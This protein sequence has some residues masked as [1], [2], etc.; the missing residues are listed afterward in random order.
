MS[1]TSCVLILA[2]LVCANGIGWSEEKDGDPDSVWELRTPSAKVALTRYQKAD[3]A[4]NGECQKRLSEARKALVADLDAALK[5][6]TR[7]ANL[8]EANRINA[9]KKRFS[10]LNSS[11][12]PPAGRQTLI[13]Y[14]AFGAY[15]KWKDVSEKVRELLAAGKNKPLTL[16][17]STTLFGDPAFGHW[18]SL[19]VVYSHDHKLGV[20][21]GPMDKPITIPSK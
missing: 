17:P 6:A 14:A 20:A 5:E 9:A 1:Q 16:V 13:H 3:E 18:K 4:A 15:D 12:W 7:G 10:E 21:I 19:V 11:A 2:V 8:E